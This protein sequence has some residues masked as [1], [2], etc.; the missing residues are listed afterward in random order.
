MKRYS[1]LCLILS[2]FLLLGGCALSP[3]SEQSSV[4]SEGQQKA[5][6]SAGSEELSQS[7]PAVQ[8]S[9]S[10]IL[11][12]YFTWADNTIVEDQEAALQSALS[13]YE[14]MGDA[15]EYNEVDAISSASIVPPGN[16]ARV[17]AWI[18]EQIGGDLFS[19][20][21]NE[22]YP[23][24]YDECMD[25]AAD[26]KAEDARPDLKSRVENIEQ[27]DTVFVGYPNWWYTCPMA[28]HSFIEGNDLSGKKIVL[29]PD[30][31]RPYPACIL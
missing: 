11:I 19:I 9:G 22:P 17:A 20:Q 7:D 12:A 27:Y 13:H 2:V 25:R 24:D 14:D 23:S 16:S 3:E 8:N 5:E 18:Q 6:E 28:I 31:K 30:K 15:D 10:D 4:S 29:L 26:E 21:V 1:L